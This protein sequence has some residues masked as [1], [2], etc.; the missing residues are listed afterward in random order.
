M[1]GRCF[2]NSPK[3][4]PTDLR[5]EKKIKNKNKKKIKKKKF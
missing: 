5:K 4:Q 3:I 2:N 1:I